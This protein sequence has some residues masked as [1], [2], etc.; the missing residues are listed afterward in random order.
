MISV[1]FIFV[2]EMTNRQTGKILHIHTTNDRMPSIARAKE[3]QNETVDQHPEGMLTSQSFR[4][5]YIH[6]SKS[7]IIVCS[8]L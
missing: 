4:G 7:L 5:R 1:S 8:P 3:E 2:A 6:E